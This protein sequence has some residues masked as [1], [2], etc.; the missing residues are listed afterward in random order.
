MGMRRNARATRVGRNPKEGTM[1]T[2]KEALQTALDAQPHYV[3]HFGT[4][5]H[6]EQYPN[7]ALAQA[8]IDG[9][10]VTEMYK[11][12]NYRVVRVQEYWERRG[13]ANAARQ[14][15]MTGFRGRRSR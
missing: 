7:R 14:A 1:M 15:V 3:I 5:W 4:G 8:W 12:A 2:T 10:G 9:Y 11:D 13:R 6:S